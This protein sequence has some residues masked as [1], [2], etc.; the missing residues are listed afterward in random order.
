MRGFLERTG[1]DRALARLRVAYA[2]LNRTQR[3]I[4]WALGGAVLLGL[5]ASL[6]PVRARAEVP[7]F[8]PG[9]IQRCLD[10]GGWRDCVGQAA[11][12]CMEATPGGWSTAGMN[13]CLDAELRW[14]D[15]D[16][17][18]QYRLVRA[19]DRAE[20]EAWEPV[21]GLPPRPSAADLVRDVQRAWIAWRDASCAYE[22]LR[23]WGGSGAS[24]AELGCRMRL[25]GEQALTLR[26]YLAE[27]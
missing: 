14:W 13:A 5:V 19:R 7:K 12:T 26:S 9:A 23:W 20:D 1:L 11:Q 3:I 8:D 18:A 27:G 25:T 24:T 15:A 21:E 16:L 10:G 17:N 6:F 22:G 2:G 4:L